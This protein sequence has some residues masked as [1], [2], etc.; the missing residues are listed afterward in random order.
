MLLWVSQA[1]LVWTDLANLY[2]QLMA[3]RSEKHFP[4][5]GL[6]IENESFMVF[7]MYS[8][9]KKSLC[10]RVIM[11]SH[12]PS[13]LFSLQP[14]AVSTESCPKSEE[15]TMV[16]RKYR[17]KVTFLIFNTLIFHTHILTRNTPQSYTTGIN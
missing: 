12:Q 15:K 17:I 6:V 13:P 11:A 14:R 7:I 9:K 10:F 16:I 4:L 8:K 3:V 2:D 5:L 1:V